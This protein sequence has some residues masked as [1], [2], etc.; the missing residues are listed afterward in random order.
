MDNFF[1]NVFK[2]ASYLLWI[3]DIN[4]STNFFIFINSVTYNFF[5]HIYTYNVCVCIK[6]S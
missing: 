5:L 4:G 2:N 1:L 6:E 3:Y